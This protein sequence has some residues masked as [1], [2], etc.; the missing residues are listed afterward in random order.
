MARAWNF[1]PREADAR[2][3]RWIV[4]RLQELWGGS[5]A[6][7][8][9]GSEN[10]PEAGHL[11]LDSGKAERRLGWRAEWDLGEALERIVEWH[12]AQRRG[13]DMRKVSLEQIERFG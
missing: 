9:D 1:G 10:P 4:E 5:F 7:E 2:T 3:V 11:A 13:E 12:E 6:W 8:L